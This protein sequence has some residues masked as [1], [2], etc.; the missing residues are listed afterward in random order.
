MTFLWEMVEKSEVKIIATEQ[1]AAEPS[2]FRLCSW[3]ICQISWPQSLIPPIRNPCVRNDS[4]ARKHSI[5]CR[6][7]CSCND[8]KS[9]AK[10][11]NRLPMHT[12]HDRSDY[13]IL[14]FSSYVIFWEKIYILITNACASAL[15]SIVDCKSHKSIPF[16]FVLPKLRTTWDLGIRAGNYSR[17]RSREGRVKLNVWRPMKGKPVQRTTEPGNCKVSE[18]TNVHRAHMEWCISTEHAVCQLPWPF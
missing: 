9:S 6:R 4:Y 11:V 15:R 10:G 16:I 7:R 14:K 18:A 8:I 3:H 2:A 17:Y 5:C 1:C 12:R 13:C